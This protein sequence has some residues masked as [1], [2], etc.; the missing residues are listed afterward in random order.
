MIDKL[1]KKIVAINAISAC[2]VFIIAV[3]IIFGTG[4]S[5]I[6]EER[7][8]RLNS[9]LNYESWSDN[10]GESYRGAAVIECDVASGQILRESFSKE[11]DLSREQLTE[12]LGEILNRTK[13][14]GSISNRVQY[15]SKIVENTARIVL[16]D[17]FSS[18]STLRAYVWYTVSAV[19]IG[20]LGYFAI[21]LILAQIVLKPIENNWAK[22]RQFV[23][24]ASHELKTPL[25]VIMA[26]TEIIASHKDE[27]VETQMK[28][29]ENTRS[30]SQRMAEL[31]ND[32]LFLAK[33][34]DGHKAQMEV[35]NFS[36]CV[37]TIVLSQESLFYE[38]GKSFTYEILPDL[39]VFGNVG[40]LK[41]LATILLDNANKYSTDNGNITLQVSATN[42]HAQLIV[43]NSCNPLTSEQLNHLFDRF[44]TVD[45]SRN[46][47][48]AGNGLGLSIAQVICQ[49]HRGK[50]SVDFADGIV[51]F[52]AALP[53]NKKLP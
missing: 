41:Q 16:F 44:Y 19:L 34:D 37:E 14:E 42:K 31:V 29:I 32:L 5:R 10:L 6:V 45:Q 9:M 1:R 48:V 24:D 39:N 15:C 3:A 23:A 20:V 7:N 36:E 38:N 33:N 30:E 35:V 17:K 21:S 50:I 13:S 25:S 40:Q 4:Y 2:L 53:L 47:S 18:A 11:F 22:Q 8:A 27:K 43:S 51:T 28:W 49:T 12:V 26:N 46:K 52:T